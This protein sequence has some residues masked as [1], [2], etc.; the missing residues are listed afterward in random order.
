MSTG[1]GPLAFKLLP[2]QGRL[3]GEERSE[4]EQLLSL[5]QGKQTHSSQTEVVAL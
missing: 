2:G 3:Q 5:A 1:A 4:V